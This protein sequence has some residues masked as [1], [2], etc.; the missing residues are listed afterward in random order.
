MYK[1]FYR[2]N[3]IRKSE[4]DKDL[5]KKLLEL[6]VEKRITIE[7]GLNHSFFKNKENDD[8]NY[9]SEKEYTKYCLSLLDTTNF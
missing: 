1:R 9:N 7:D 2:H 5:I 3:C 6:D 4:A 8:S